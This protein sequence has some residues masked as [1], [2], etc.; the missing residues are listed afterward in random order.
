MA[1]PLNIGSAPQVVTMSYYIGGITKMKIGQVMVLALLVLMTLSGI[2][3]AQY[4][5]VN[6]E[7][8]EIDDVRVYDDA[9]VRLD[10][11]RNEKFDV[12]LE[13]MAPEAVDDVTIRATIDG[14]EYGDV[15][16]ITDLLGPFD[17][18]A[19]VTYPKRLELMLPEDMD[20]DRYKLRIMISDK[21]SYSEVWE[22]NLLV[23]APRHLLRI[24]D[25]TFSP[26]RTVTSGQALIGSVRVENKGQKVQRDV[27]VEVSIPA[28]GI[29]SVDY[30]ERIDDD[31]EEEET[32][33]FFLRLPECAEPGVYD[34]KV[35]VQYNKGRD[36]VQETT[37]VT[38]LENEAC[39]EEEQAIVV[40]QETQPVQPAETA[41][42]APE[43]STLRTVLEVILVVLVA[44]LVLVGLVIVLTRLRE[45]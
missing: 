45:E 21:D 17:L 34:V 31:D 13:L 14:Y 19:N 29:E 15:E 6:L 35:E 2:A 25:I 37:Q 4:I 16:P 5:P 38:V 18:E 40:I 20:V 41:A 11:E 43:K 44:L 1:K 22:Y 33:E 39:K 24:D 28:L 8:V 23:G 10:V 36:L 32:E 42:P 9:D 27:R 3:S 26:G 12:E 7:R 30:I